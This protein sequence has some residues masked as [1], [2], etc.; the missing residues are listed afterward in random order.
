[1][2][3]EI[4]QYLFCALYARI[5]LHK[6]KCGE[7]MLLIKNPDSAGVCD[8]GGGYRDFPRSEAVLGIVQD[9]G[10]SGDGT[11]KLTSPISQIVQASALTHVGLDIGVKLVPHYLSVGIEL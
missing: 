8:S 4:G 2:S 3:H 1:M 6:S 11:R 7:S 9:S 10:Y 5:C